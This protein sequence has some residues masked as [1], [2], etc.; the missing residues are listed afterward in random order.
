MNKK[1]QA[2]QVLEE[3]RTLVVELQHLPAHKFQ[4]RDR[5]L[6]EL[7]EEAR[8]LKDLNYEIEKVVL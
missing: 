6:R 3:I 2:K 8:I 1:E 5:L 4:E 7:I